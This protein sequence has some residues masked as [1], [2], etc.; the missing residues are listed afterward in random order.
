MSVLIEFIPVLILVCL[1][2]MA[3]L[4]GADTEAARQIAQLQGDQPMTVHNVFGADENAT[5]RGDD[6]GNR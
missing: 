2:V 4:A 5:M 6:Y 3:I 1:L